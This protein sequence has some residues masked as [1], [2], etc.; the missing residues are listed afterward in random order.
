[1]ESGRKNMMAIVMFA[2]AV[3]MMAALFPPANEN[4]AAANPTQ[5]TSSAKPSTQV[6]SSSSP[7]QVNYSENATKAIA[8]TSLNL[9]GEA[10][11]RNLSLSDVALLRHLAQLQ[12]AIL[13]EIGEM[14]WMILHGYPHHAVHSLEKIYYLAK[15]GEYLCPAD[16]FSHV[17]P[18]LAF[19]ET[20]LAMEVAE[21]GAKQ[22][23]EWTD[24]ARAVK[25]RTPTAYPGGLDELISAM[26][27]T[28]IEMEE[29]NYAAALEDAKYVEKNGY[30]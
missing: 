5:T 6:A 3:V 16:A 2:A 22:L 17:G 25:E 19:N 24:K 15:G 4:K 8:R 10:Q 11:D 1:M 27:R 30:C 29:G 23:G 21:E 14:E 12:P 18:Y 28:A 13:D 26:N 7:K 9:E 20:E